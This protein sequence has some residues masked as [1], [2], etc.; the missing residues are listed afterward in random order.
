LKLD[1]QQLDSF[2]KS[3]L[4]DDYIEIKVLEQKEAKLT[5]EG[6]KYAATGT[7]EV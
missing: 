5:E 4:V 3:L 6:S 7:P 2:L 1:H